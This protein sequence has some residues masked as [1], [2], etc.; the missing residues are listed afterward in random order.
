MF[1]KE[2]SFEFSKFPKKLASKELFSRIKLRHIGGTLCVS[3]IQYY[4]FVQSVNTCS[5]S[6]IEVSSNKN[7]HNHNLFNKDY[8]TPE[9]HL[10]CASV[11][12]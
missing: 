5:K 6:M 2:I 1:Q 7:K 3:G 10:D 12:C 4:H 11:F 8:G 9:V